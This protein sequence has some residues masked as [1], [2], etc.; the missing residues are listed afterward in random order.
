M[1]TFQMW[2]LPLAWLVWGLLA[3]WP[4]GYRY[5]F[6]QSTL[7]IGIVLIAMLTRD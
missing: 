3:S 6:T 1:T 7:V 4:Y 2:F 5:G